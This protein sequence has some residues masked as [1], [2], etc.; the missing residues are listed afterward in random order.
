MPEIGK[1]SSLK[2]SVSAVIDDGEIV[3]T[4]SQRANVGNIKKITI[5][6]IP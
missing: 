3:G 5:V 2:L 1:F 6:S 4:E